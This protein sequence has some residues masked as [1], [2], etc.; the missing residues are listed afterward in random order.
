M[1]TW[2]DVHKLFADLHWRLVDVMMWKLGCVEE[3]CRVANVRC[4]S[5]DEGLAKYSCCGPARI[6]CRDIQEPLHDIVD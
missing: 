2:K 3:D 6:N 5:V 1:V 4:G